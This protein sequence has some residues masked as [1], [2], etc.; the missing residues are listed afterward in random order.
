MKKISFGLIIVL[1]LF[2]IVHIASAIPVHNPYQFKN[3]G[4]KISLYD[5][6]NAGSIKVAADIVLGQSSDSSFN[7]NLSKK[8]LISYQ[9]ISLS[10]KQ[11]RNQ[12][13][14]ENEWTGQK[15]GNYRGNIVLNTHNDSETIS[16]EGYLLP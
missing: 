6:K 11:T 12:S 15:K 14:V 8:G 5:S 16:G 4:D 1:S 7:L 3:V 9:F 10:V 13:R 2:L